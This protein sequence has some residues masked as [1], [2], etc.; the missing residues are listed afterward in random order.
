M[1][2]TPLPPLTPHP[3][4]E[5]EHAHAPQ[6]SGRLQCVKALSLLG[7]DRDLFVQIGQAYLAEISDFPTKLNALLENSRWDD[8]M[9]AFHT[10]KGLSLTV[11]ASSLASLCGRVEMQTKGLRHAANAPLRA[12]LVQELRNEVDCTSNALAALI[13]QWQRQDAATPTPRA[14]LAGDRAALVCDLSA[15][16]KLLGQSDLHAL[17]VH[18]ALRKRHTFAIDQLQDLHAS[19]LA[20]DFPKAVVQCGELIREFTAQK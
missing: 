9:R 3:V 6:Q 11:G 13:A 8:A 5:P 12:A 4:A 18:S 7:D 14:A 19:V 2:A 17:D 16:L 20:F 15:L 10:I 1:P